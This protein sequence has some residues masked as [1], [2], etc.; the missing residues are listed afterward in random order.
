[1]NIGR[2]PTDLDEV[3]RLAKPVVVP[4]FGSVI[5]KGPTA[6]TIIT[7]HR[8]HVMMQA[9]Y[10]EDETNLPVGLYVF[11]NNCKMKDSS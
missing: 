2:E 10:L 6:E 3:V 11:C 1:M 7:G 8:L 4:A 5:V 9:P